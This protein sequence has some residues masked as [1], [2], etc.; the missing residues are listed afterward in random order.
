MKKL[1][2]ILMMLCMV[3]SLCACGNS[4]DNTE[5]DTEKN[6]ESSQLPESEKDENEKDTTA[7]GKVHYTVKVQDDKGN[8]I[9]GALIQLCATSCFPTTTNAE[10]VAEWDLEEAEYKA[11]FLNVDTP[12]AGYTYST[13][14]KEFYF[15]SGATEL[16]IVL[17]AVEG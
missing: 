12:A 7:T 1:L 3:V 8:P 6:S 14:A 9:A 2:T 5:K 11:S 15:E 10:G 13:D 4:G 17:K 16:T